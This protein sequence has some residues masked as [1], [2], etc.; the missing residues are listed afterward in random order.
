[1]GKEQS[2]GVFVIFGHMSDFEE[3]KGL[4]CYLTSLNFKKK[5]K[6]NKK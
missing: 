2:A 6:V 5:K 3:K 1:M 4:L